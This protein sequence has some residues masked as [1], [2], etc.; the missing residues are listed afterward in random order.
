MVKKVDHRRR[1]D[2][3]FTLVELMMSMGLSTV[4]LM[5]LMTMQ[6]I[7]VKGNMASRNFAE[8]TGIAQ[9]RVEQAQ[10]V[11][12]A[13]LPS[14]DTTSAPETV[15]PSPGSPAAQK[16]YAR[17]TTVAVDGANNVTTVTVSVSWADVDSNARSHSVQLV[18]RR[19]P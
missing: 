19:S 16:V 1:R 8:A 7:S 4:G 5:G 3:G 17:T 9:E 12:Y 2:R 10:T 15:G 14:L 6:G 11:S 18:S 13:L